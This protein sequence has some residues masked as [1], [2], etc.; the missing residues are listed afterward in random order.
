MSSRNV[1]IR[2]DVYDA[3]HKEK[4]PGESFTMLFVRLLNQKPPL[5]QALGSWGQSDRRRSSRLLRQLRG[6]GFGGPK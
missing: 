4:R 6:G 2:K 3:L 1:A 5:E